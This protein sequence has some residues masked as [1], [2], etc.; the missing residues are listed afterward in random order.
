[1]KKWYSLAGIGMLACALVLGGCGGTEEKPAKTEEAVTIK[2]GASPVPH[3]EILDNIKEKLA[4]DGVNMEIIEF[5]DYIQPNLALNDKELDANYFQHIPYLENFAEEHELNL[6]NL[7]GVH[8]EPMGVYSNSLDNLDALADEAKVAIPNDPTN[9]G[10]ALLLLQTAGLITLDPEAGILATVT[11]ITDNPKQLQFAE[12]E[13]AQIPRALDDVAIAVINTNYAI[14]A[15]LNPEADA[16]QLEEKDSPYV[17]IV[18]VRA[19]DE[20]REELKKLLNALQSD[21]TANYIKEKYNGAVITA[22]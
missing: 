10:R 15:G 20:E 9:G 8:I 18:A 4:N 21:E 6:V 17:N 5:T 7:G 14:E 3:A 22:F 16:L 19:G 12:L 13:A 1:M 11:D 2:V